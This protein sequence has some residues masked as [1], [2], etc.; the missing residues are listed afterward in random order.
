MPSAE[1]IRDAA[2]RWAVLANT[3]WPATTA[4][5]ASAATGATWPQFIANGDAMSPVNGGLW[6]VRPSLATYRDGLHVLGRCRYNGSHGGEGA[7]P[8]RGLHLTPR[9]TDGRRV[10]SD[11]GDSPTG[12]DAYTRNDWRFVGGATDQARDQSLTLALT[13][14]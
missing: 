12:N 8:P 2:G 9:H 3:L 10:V 14:R 11:A 13:D 6:L 7:G 1:R 5:D 4:A